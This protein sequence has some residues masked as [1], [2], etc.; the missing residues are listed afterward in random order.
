MRRGVTAVMTVLCVL[1]GVGLGA[2]YVTKD[3][4]GPEI[5]IPD[6][7]KS[8]VEGSDTKD[9]LKGVKAKDKREGDVTKTLMIEAVRPNADRTKAVVVY[10][11]KDSKNNV[12]K[13]S[14]T[15][16]YRT[17]EAADS[18]EPEADEKEPEPTQEPQPDDTQ[19]ADAPAVPDPADEP[20]TDGEA[21]NAEAIKNLPNG[22][23]EIQLVQ[24]EISVPLG[25]AFKPLTYVKSIV[26]DV[27]EKD[28][29]YQRVQIDGEVNTAAAGNYELHYHV[30]DSAGNSSNVAVLKVT[31]Q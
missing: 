21:A 24:Y 2:I 10:V 3:N 29:L 8:Y 13:K 4:K 22:S 12:T 15:V 11:A 25:S 14:R 7:N 17:A 19:P 18:S 26:D 23:P 30:V 6:G 5:T 9:L 27:D 28:S 20:Q 31:V 1:M 16:D